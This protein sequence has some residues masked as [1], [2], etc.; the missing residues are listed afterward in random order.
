MKNI[1]TGV[2]NLGLSLKTLNIFGQGPDYSNI[3]RLDI[4]ISDRATYRG[5]RSLITRNCNNLIT[6]Q[7][8]TPQE[9]R[10][11]AGTTEKYFV[12]SVLLSSTM[13]LTPKIDEVAFAIKQNQCD[14]A[15][16][17]WLKESIPD[18]SVNIEGYQ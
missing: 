1:G 10:N 9:N 8:Q 17:T 4:R 18:V 5:S 6:I 11:E 16:E 3:L 2:T 15:A 12:P 7:T 13:S 14:I